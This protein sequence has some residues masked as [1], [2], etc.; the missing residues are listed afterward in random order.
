VG[1]IGL[2]G[3]TGIM[4]SFLVVP[5]ARDRD[6]PDQASAIASTVSERSYR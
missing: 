4:V 2:A 6:V 1:S 3:I 5:P